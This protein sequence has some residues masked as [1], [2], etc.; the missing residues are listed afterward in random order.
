MADGKSPF[1]VSTDDAH[2]LR[3]TAPALLPI[4]HARRNSILE[5]LQ[6]EFRSGVKDFTHTIAE[7][8]T[9]SDLIREL[10]RKLAQGE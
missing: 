5:R 2:I 10:E 1:A 7:F 4:L 3:V 6:G 8:V 9:Y